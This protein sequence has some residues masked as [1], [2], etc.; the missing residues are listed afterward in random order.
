MLTR[1]K[2]S[3]E[4]QLYLPVS[5]RRKLRPEVETRREGRHFI[6][7]ING[8]ERGGVKK[9]LEWFF[10]APPERKAELS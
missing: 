3:K 6:K 5:R 10:C 1:G 4:L 9:E 8:K 7:R 2:V